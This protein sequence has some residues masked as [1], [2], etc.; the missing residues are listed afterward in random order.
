MS[1]RSGKSAASHRTKGGQRKE[2]GKDRSPK[3]DD[4]RSGDDEVAMLK[5]ELDALTA[6]RDELDDRLAYMT[7]EFENLKRRS[8]RD[9]ENMLFRAK[10][11]LFLDLIGII[12][13]LD[14]AQQITDGTDLETFMKGIRMI[15]VQL[16]QVL[17][18]HGLTTIDAQEKDF[19][20]F[21]HEAI[22]RVEDRERKDGLIIEEVQK[23][24]TL[25]GKV[26][27]PS[28]VRVNVHRTE[29]GKEGDASDVAKGPEGCGDEEA[30]KG[31]DN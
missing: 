3:A 17:A 31:G 16:R 14:R 8:A 9:V 1:Q 2:K 26:V 12:D 25:N 10:E 30:G 11:S 24:Y 29:N 27:R 7:A 20:P 4:K 23:G 5:K 13:N 21:L 19:D 15:D 28:K 6:E 18:E 22:E